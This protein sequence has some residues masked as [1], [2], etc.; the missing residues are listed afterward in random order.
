MVD[1]SD[2]YQLFSG[3]SLPADQYTLVLSSK[4][5]PQAAFAW[6]ATNSPGLITFGAGYAGYLV[7]LGQEVASFAP[8]SDF[9]SLIIGGIPPLFQV[10]AE[11][12]LNNVPEPVPTWSLAGMCAV[13]VGARCMI[14]RRRRGVKE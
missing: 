12:E 8:A 2:N 7:A 6:N 9:G 11:I 13:V 5:G 14:A 1:A 4:I 10:T 3:L